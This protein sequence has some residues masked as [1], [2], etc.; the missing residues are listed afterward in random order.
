M[1]DSGDVCGAR[2]TQCE[3]E[4]LRLFLGE[5]MAAYRWRDR[6]GDFCVADYLSKLDTVHSQNQRL[7]FQIEINE[8][9]TPGDEHYLDPPGAELAWFKKSSFLSMAGSLSGRCK[10]GPHQR[11][12][13]KIWIGD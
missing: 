5:T 8:S 6:I 9:K 10:S 13:R 2:N 7:G 1:R 3:Q 12:A 4:F 11:S